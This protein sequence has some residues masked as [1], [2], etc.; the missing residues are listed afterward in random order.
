APSAALASFSQLIM[1]LIAA[2]VRHAIALDQMEAA[3]MLTLFKRMLPR[4]LAALEA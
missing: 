4:N 3:R 2:A 1:T